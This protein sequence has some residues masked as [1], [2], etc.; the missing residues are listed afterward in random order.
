MKPKWKILH[1]SLKEYLLYL[2]WK[3][4]RKRVCTMN[5]V[6]KADME[7]MVEFP[8]S[9]KQWKDFMRFQQEYEEGSIQH[10]DEAFSLHSE[11]LWTLFEEKQTLKRSD[12]DEN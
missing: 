10:N 3:W 6:M 7:Q 8:I 2:L 12:P 9:N 11:R 4:Y 5:C 1:Y